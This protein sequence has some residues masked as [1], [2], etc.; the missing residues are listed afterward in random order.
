MPYEPPTGERLE[1]MLRNAHASRI[2][3]E[4]AAAKLLAARRAAR[5]AEESPNIQYLRLTNNASR[6][7]NNTMP[8][9]MDELEVY[10]RARQANTSPGKTTKPTIT[11]GMVKLNP[12][13]N[14]YGEVV[15]ITNSFDTI[16]NVGNNHNNNNNNNSITVSNIFGE[17]GQLPQRTRRGG[18]RRKK[19][20]TR[21]NKR[22]TRRRAH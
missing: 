2:A 4:Q 19:R 9:T 3:I 10:E 11:Q 15:N 14:N 16:Q 18:Q 22:A 12:T 20:A 13:N 17:N 5:N 1:Q 6:L 8:M 7:P 21:R